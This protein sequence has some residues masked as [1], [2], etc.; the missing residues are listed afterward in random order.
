LFFSGIFII[1]AFNE[2]KFYDGISGN[3]SIDAN[4]ALGQKIVNIQGTL[5]AHEAIKQQEYEKALQLIS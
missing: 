4:T 5:Q 2:S 3:I 1:R